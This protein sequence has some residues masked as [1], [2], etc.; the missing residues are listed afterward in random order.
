M[1]SERHEREEQERKGAGD[2]MDGMDGMDGN[3]VS[4]A[5]HSIV[6]WADASGPSASNPRPHSHMI[7][8]PWTMV[9]KGSLPPVI[10]TATITVTV[11]ITIAVAV[12]DCFSLPAT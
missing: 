11:T 9:N 4:T 1:G 10:V 2:G 3:I 7:V 8:F 6:M 5:L 12:W